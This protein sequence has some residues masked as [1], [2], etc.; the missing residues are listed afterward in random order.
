MTNREIGAALFLGDQT[1]KTHVSSILRK[2]HLPNRGRAA[3]FAAADP[4]F[5]RIRS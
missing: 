4:D 5:R 3:A 2:L 1:V